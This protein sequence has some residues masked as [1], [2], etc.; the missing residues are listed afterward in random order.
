MARCVA[1]RKVKLK[2]SVN[3]ESANMDYG[4]NDDEIPILGA[5]PVNEYR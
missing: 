4:T 3:V 5:V 1:C 2:K